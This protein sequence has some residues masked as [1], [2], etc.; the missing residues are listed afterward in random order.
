MSKP[1]GSIFSSFGGVFGVLCPACSVPIATFLST[2]GLGFL[3]N[4]VVSRTITVVL[5]GLALIALHTSSLVHRRQSAF[6]LAVVAG[7]AMIAS[8]NFYLHPW[9]VYASGIGLV[10]AAALDFYYRR[11]APAV[12]CP[13]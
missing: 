6:V 8:R 13:T 1:F 9:L 12:V 2:L 10:A 4:F 11:K 5:I 3:A 7:M